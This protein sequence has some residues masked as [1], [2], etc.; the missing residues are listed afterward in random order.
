MPKDSGGALWSSI[1]RLHL[2]LADAGPGLGLARRRAASP[3]AGM[4]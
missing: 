3:T 2:L 1:D 4:R